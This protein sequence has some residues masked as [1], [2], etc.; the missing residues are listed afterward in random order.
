MFAAKLVTKDYFGFIISLP[1]RQSTHSRSNQH[2][3]K[4][5]FLRVFRTFGRH[6]I[7]TINDQIRKYRTIWWSFSS[8][9]D[10]IK[11]DHNTVATKRQFTDIYDCKLYEMTVYIIVFDCLD[12]CNQ[13]SSWDILLSFSLSRLGYIF[14]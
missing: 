4:R 3:H 8:V 7:T 13:S 5:P 2:G 10:K 11:H 1:T 6:N 12:Y 14:I 9:Y